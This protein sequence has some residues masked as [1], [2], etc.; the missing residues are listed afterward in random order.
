MGY[1]FKKTFAAVDRFKQGAFFFYLETGELDTKNHHHNK[2]QFVY[3]EGGYIYIEVAGRVCFLPARHFMWIP[4]GVTHRI[5]SQSPAVHMFTIY[6]E[7]NKT[8]EAFYRQPGIYYVNN[9][10][11][12]MILHTRGWAG[13]IGPGGYNRYMF[14]MAI[15]AL[16]PSLRGN[17]GSLNYQIPTP[18]T[19]ILIAVTRFAVSHLDE[20]ITLPTLAKKFGTSPRT[21]SRLFMADM[22]TSYIKYLTT[23]RIVKAFEL[24]AE[25]R[26]SIKEIAYQL[27]YSSVPTFSNIFYSHTG[28]RP[29]HYMGQQ[30]Q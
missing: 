6:F 21:L 15:K 5:W 25:G 1:N 16:L 26:H 29:T 8:D 13:H 12:E 11:R 19:P 30:Q 22:G 9:L 24:L 28:I 2:G 7:A 10:L 17:T 20:P 18:T 23:L 27:G 14:A 3:T 4:A